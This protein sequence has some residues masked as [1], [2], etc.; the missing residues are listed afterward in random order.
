MGRVL[1]MTVGTGTGLDVEKKTWNLAHGLLASIDHYKPDRVVF[2][3]SEDSK[4]TIET[5][6]SIESLN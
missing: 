6:E 5:I 3:G 4:V 2:F 1:F